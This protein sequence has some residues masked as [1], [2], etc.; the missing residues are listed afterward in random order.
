MKTGVCCAVLLLVGIGCTARQTTE[1]TDQQKTQIKSEVTA[2]GDSII[3]RWVRLD[4][5]GAMEYYAPDVLVVYNTATMD[6]QTYKQGW[7]AY[8]SSMAAVRVAPIRQD[9]LPLARNLAV[10]TWVGNVALILK[11][12]DTITTDPQIYSNVMKKVVGR[13]LVVYSNPSGVDVRHK[14]GQA[15]RP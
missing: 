12:G 3:A 7:L 10:M 2:V 13:W 9:I 11:S 14:A 4:G 8:D 6:F 15:R 5:G 1:L